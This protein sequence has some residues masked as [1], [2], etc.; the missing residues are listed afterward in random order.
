MLFVIDGG[1]AIRKALRD[2]FGDRAIVQRCQVHSATRKGWSEGREGCDD[3]LK[4]CLSSSGCE[5]RPARVDPHRPEASLARRA[6]THG[7]MRRHASA[8]AVGMR[9]RKWLIRDAQNLW[10]LK[11]KAA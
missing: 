1:K 7:A 9:P 2:V 5:T 4:F 6:A 11:A 3:F 8:R 10:N